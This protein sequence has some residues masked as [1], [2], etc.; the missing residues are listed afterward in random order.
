M[1]NLF[2]SAAPLIRAL[3]WTLIHS[4]WQG[5][6]IALIA[7][8]VILFTRKA[9]AAL[10]YN[11]LSILFFLFLTVVVYTFLRQWHSVPV[12]ERLGVISDTQAVSIGGRADLS[13]TTI[14]TGILS[15]N[16]QE[17]FVGYFN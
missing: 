7:G 13:E 2:M 8:V 11:L 1:Q 15:G 16:Y 17:A 4:L 14:S 12:S 10:R 6:L 3:S 5:L 9:T